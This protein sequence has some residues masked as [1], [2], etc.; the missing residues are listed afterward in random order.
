MS[1][2]G[3]VRAAVV[4]ALGEDGALMALVNGLYDGV[5]VQASAPYI[6]VADCAG[7]DWGAKGVDG[8]EVRLSIALYDKGEGSAAIAAMLARVEAAMRGVGGVVGG[9]RIV[10]VRFVRSRVAR[11]VASQRR[12]GGWQGVVDYRVRVVVEG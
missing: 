4:A 1:A 6:V 8:R 7:A 5:P 9:W 11:A 2:E 3:A 10:T 12:D